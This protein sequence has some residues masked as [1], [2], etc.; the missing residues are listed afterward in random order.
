MNNEKTPTF[1]VSVTKDATTVVID[2]MVALIANAD[3]DIISI[4]YSLDWGDT[5]AGEYSKNFGKTT[6]L[7]LDF[8][9]V[10]TKK[11]IIRVKNNNGDVVDTPVSINV[12]KG[13]AIQIKSI[14]LNSFFNMGK[15]WDSEFS[16]TDADRLADVFFVLLKPRL[17]VF[18]G[19]RS[20]TPNSTWI[21]FKSET[22]QNENNLN[23][24][25]Q[26]ENVFINIDQLT[27]WIAFA[28]DDG[29]GIAQDLMLVPPF[30]RTI[31]ISDYTSTK[32]NRI[33]VEETNINLKYEL[34]I[35]W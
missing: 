26:N 9:T 5:Y 6:N 11:I 32:P 34:T 17:N 22:R 31:P 30:E 35:D 23:W 27:P 33:L 18:D 19:T 24:D 20:N 1:T 15:T 2:Q 8:D 13:N 25:L 28:D 16:D 12:E 14:Q 3:V 29:G 21:W 4:D 7:Y 10:G